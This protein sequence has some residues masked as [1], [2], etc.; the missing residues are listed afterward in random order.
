MKK[1]YKILPV[2]ALSALIAVSAFVTPTFAQE[3]TSQEIN[4]E[5]ESSEIEIDAPNKAPEE[6]EIVKKIEDPTDEEA[7]AITVA[8]GATVKEMLRAIAA[9]DG[10]DQTYKVTDEDGEKKKG[11]SELTTGDQLTVTAE[12]GTTAT[13]EIYEKESSEIEIHAPNK[14]PAEL[15]VI[16]KIDEPTDEEA[17]AIT[18]A[19]GATV[20][21][22]LRAIAAPDGS[23]QTY[24][25]TDE[26]G[27]K[28]KGKSE[29]TTGD[30]LTVTAED[31]T[32]ATYE[33]YEK[34]SSEIEID[35]PNKAPEELEIV[36]KIE[37]PTDEEAGEIT[38]ANGA[39]V[40]EM[41]RAI[42]APDG[43]DQ[44]YKVTDENG[45]KK[46]GKSELTTGDQLTVTAED[47]TTAT[48]E[49]YEKES[50]E[51][52]IDAPNKA[53][54][55]LEIVKKIEE[56]TDEEAGEITV[57]NDATVKEML[58]AIAATDG[59]DQTY[60]VTD[61]DGKVKKGKR[62]LATGDQLTVTAED[63]TT[64]TYDIKVKDPAE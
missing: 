7:G 5:E 3:A 61:E 11:K 21:E 19:N 54:E 49:V 4:S 13:Y 10:S 44:T 22:M 64:A 48:Y 52:E 8:N 25:V 9:P 6:L 23:D 41:L 34:E 32:T 58:R 1:S 51:I 28:K 15:K 56:P 38:V 12:D 2:S 60:K 59:S 62:E 33:V 53:P 31:G 47:G 45:E 40:K 63:G 24:K 55:E 20:K 14:A 16:W 46:K 30:Q 42:A 39:T 35:A 26:D 57:A 50:S 18:V 27:E 17:G 43:S 37:E 29:L 36:K